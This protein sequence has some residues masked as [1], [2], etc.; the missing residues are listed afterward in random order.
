MKTTEENNT[1][2][3]FELVTSEVEIVHYTGIYEVV[4]RT[5]DESISKFNDPKKRYQEDVLNI[6]MQT[7]SYE[8]FNAEVAKKYLDGEIPFIS[9][10]SVEKLPT[11]ETIDKEDAK[12]KV[13]SLVKEIEQLKEKFNI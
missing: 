13:Q 2:M 6:D 10:E 5:K 4:A 8:D 3:R 9:I 12:N 1:L 7:D 11:K